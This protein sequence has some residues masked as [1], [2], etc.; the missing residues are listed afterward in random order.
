MWPLIVV[1]FGVLAGACSA[2]P[3]AG[4]SATTG[5]TVVQTASATASASVGPI[6]SFPAGCPNDATG[7]ATVPRVSIADV[8]PQG[9]P[10]YDAVVFDFDRGLPDYEITHVEPP[11]TSDP[12]GK[13]L[14]V[15][16]VAFFSIVFRGASIV[17]EEFQSVYKGPTDL[18]PNL[19][20]IQEV[21]MSGDF[22]AVSSW[23]VGL[24]APACLAAQAVSGTRLVVAFGDAP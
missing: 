1:T 7:T 19:Q 20:R 21:V 11:F 17:D 18:Q 8:E 12:S 24:H 5:P 2:S 14:S 4:P 9:Y 13:P 3:T 22:E 16:G 23:I 15:Q 10:D 6:S